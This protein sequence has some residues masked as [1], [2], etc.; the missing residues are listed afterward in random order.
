MSSKFSQYYS[1]IRAK[2]QELANRFPNGDCLVIC[3]GC[4]SE[5]PVRLAAQLLIEGSHR[6]ATQD[7]ADAFRATRAMN[8]ATTSQVDTLANARAQFAVLMA[9]KKGEHK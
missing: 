8:R 9:T 4:V 7:E 1:E 5:V 2:G 3:K 6:L